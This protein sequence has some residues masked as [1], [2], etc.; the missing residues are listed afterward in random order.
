M[1][2]KCKCLPHHTTGQAGGKKVF[3]TAV[4]SPVYCTQHSSLDT[5]LNTWTE[6]ILIIKKNAVFVCACLYSVSLCSLWQSPIHQ[7][8]AV[9][10]RC[11]TNPTTWWQ[12]MGTN[13]NLNKHNSRLL[14]LTHCFC[15]FWTNPAL[16]S[17]CLCLSVCV[18]VWFCIWGWCCRQCCTWHNDEGGAHHS[19]YLPVHPSSILL[20]ASSDHL[21]F[22]Q[23]CLKERIPHLR[24]LCSPL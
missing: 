14:T 5:S 21:S 17:G 10:C 13:K 16:L 12:Q 22:N 1:S 4:D 7:Q 9:M 3:T 6:K 18:C 23:Y 15:K 20:M 2:S 11:R 8:C 24:T 19:L